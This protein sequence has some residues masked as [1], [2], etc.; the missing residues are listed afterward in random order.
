MRKK[1]F[2]AKI[3]KKIITRTL[4]YNTYE[5]YSIK[6]K[7]MVYNESSLQN[8]FGLTCIPQGIGF[9]TEPCIISLKGGAKNIRNRWRK[10]AFHLVF[11]LFRIFL[12]KP[13]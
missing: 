1:F 13:S 5:V 3:S 2:L 10:Q 11:N 8:N 6:G 4:D 12:R 7:K 9:K